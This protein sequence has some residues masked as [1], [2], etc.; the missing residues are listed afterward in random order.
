MKRERAS[1]IGDGKDGSY[2]A[3][4]GGNTGALLRLRAH[5]GQPGDIIPPVCHCCSER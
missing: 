1:L 2:A 4:C 5:G 3:V